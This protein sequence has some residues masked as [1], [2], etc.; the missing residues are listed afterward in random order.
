MCLVCDESAFLRE[1]LRGEMLTT[2][3]DDNNNQ[4]NIYTKHAYTYIPVTARLADDG[5]VGGKMGSVNPFR[6]AVPFWGQTT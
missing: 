4:R 1:D 6:T 3:K 2:K 5:R